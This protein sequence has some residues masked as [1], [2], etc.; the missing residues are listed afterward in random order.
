MDEGQKATWASF[1]VNTLRLF[2]FVHCLDIDFPGLFTN[3]DLCSLY[4]W[5]GQNVHLLIFVKILIFLNRCRLLRALSLYLLFVKIR[6]CADKIF[7]TF[8]NFLLDRIFIFC[9]DLNSAIVC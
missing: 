3:R 9:K 2:V 1:T 4:F 6:I 8:T 5:T 7:V